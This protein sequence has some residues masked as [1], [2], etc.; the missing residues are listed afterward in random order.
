MY[1]KQR[2][3]NTKNKISILTK[4]IIAIDDKISKVFLP[5]IETF[6]NGRDK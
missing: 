2:K 3:Q 5:N 1:K 6:P 4:I